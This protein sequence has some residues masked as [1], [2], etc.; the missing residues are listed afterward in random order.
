MVCGNS[1]VWKGSPKA[2]NVTAAC[3][4]AWDQAVQDCMPGEGF[5]DLLQLIDGH[6]EQ[7][8][9]MADDPR[10]SLLSATGSTKMGKA[11]APLVAAR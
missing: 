5:E 9:W 1:V 6:K 4:K 10:I 2:L 8:E 3:K 11:L 7:A